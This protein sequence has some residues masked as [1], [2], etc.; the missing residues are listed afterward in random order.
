MWALILCL[1]ESGIIEIPESVDNS[2]YLHH[3]H[4]R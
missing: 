3:G 1:L 2:S 4:E